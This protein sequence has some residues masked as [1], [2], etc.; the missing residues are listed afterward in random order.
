M[1]SEHA[2]CIPINW[3]KDSQ[4]Y[5]IYTNE[6]G[7]YELSFSS[8]Q[9]PKTKDIGRHCYNVLFLQ[10]QQQ[11]TNK[12]N[13]EHQQAVKDHG[14]QIKDLE[15]TN[16]K[17]QQKILRL[18]KEID[19]VIA[20]RHIARRGCFDN[21]LSFIK[22]NDRKVHLYYVIRCQYRQLKKHN[23]WLKSR[24]PSMEVTEKCDDSNAI[25]RWNRFK[26]EVIKKPN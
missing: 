11:L 1:S 23:R 9:Q 22:K 13:E 2:T 21:V 5:D 20:N 7:M 18:N 12:M 14:N 17:H 10:M 8:Q 24:Y 15:F 25:H 19:D 6:E 16:K 3:P 4:K 26:R